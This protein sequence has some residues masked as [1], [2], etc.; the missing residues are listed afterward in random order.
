MPMK[1]IGLF[2]SMTMRKK[3]LFIYLVAILIPFLIAGSLYI[4]SIHGA[5]ERQSLEMMRSRTFHYTQSVN[6]RLSVF[7][8]LTNLVAN[9]AELMKE[10]EGQYGSVLDALHV[11]QR[12]WDQY[13]SHRLT[14]PN[15][16]NITIY[17]TNPTLRN[18]FPYVL[19]MDS[20]MADLPEYEEI[21]AFSNMGRWYGPRYC[22][23]REYWS[24]VN[25]TLTAGRVRTFSFNR[26]LYSR[27]RFVVPIG[28]LTIEVNINALI[29]LIE[30]QDG[31]HIIIL[32]ENDRIVASSDEQWDGKD[33]FAVALQTEDDPI[34][35]RVDGVDYFLDSSRLDNGWRIIVMMPHH[36]AFAG[37]DI[38]WR[39]GIIWLAS[40]SGVIVL[41]IL[42]ISKQISLRFSALITKMAEFMG[43]E[44]VLGEP[45][46]GDDEIGRLDRDFT[47]LA[48]EL[49]Q[50]IDE[51][52]VLE[53]QKNRF[54]LQ[55]LQTQINPH[56]LYNTLSTIAW[57]SDNNPREE[58]RAAVEHLA[59]F[60]RQT[61]SEGKDV[62]ALK[63]ELQG[64]KAYIELQRIRFVNRLQ[65][66]YD[67][68]QLALE[69]PI[70]KLTIQP[71]VE[72]SIR[73]GL[74]D[75][76]ESLSIMIAVRID[77]DAVTISVQDDGV[78]MLK[79]V[80]DKLLA[81]DL[82]GESGGGLG[83]RN[84]NDR[85]KSYFGAEYGLSASSQ[86]GVGTVVLI[87]VPFDL[88]QG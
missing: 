81:G 23:T 18:S 28:M 63:D 17:S 77:A 27:E 35:R 76:R 43:G 83:F 36:Q 84:V 47:I 66:Y 2:N 58:I 67:V 20:Y 48:K 69:T 34:Q 78:G 11:Y 61:L 44:M 56:F 87:R 24:P 22:N 13:T 62:V 15:L 41:L 70:P 60:Y 31:L 26:V 85:I 75:D 64:V 5:V 57:L 74:R 10:L 72:N 51:T 49:K 6:A 4:R 21:L 80:L 42:L 12:V 86:Q 59:A 46:G 82:E 53:L 55:A 32:D 65:I 38:L 19:R 16:Q 40:I 54:Y 50:R 1:I 3:M 14:W 68:D 25:A 33:G 71:I 9:N 30:T 39:Y 8:M 29:E 73:H 79:D 45:I 7:T 88:T 37:S 52:Y